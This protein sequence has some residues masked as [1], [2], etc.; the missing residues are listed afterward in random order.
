VRRTP[1]PAATAFVP[2]D[3]KGG[4]NNWSFA[5]NC[6]EVEARSRFVWANS[7][8]VCFGTFR[9]CDYARAKSLSTRGS[10]HI[11]TLS[12]GYWIALR[13]LVFDKLFSTYPVKLSVRSGIE[14]L[15]SNPVRPI[16]T[17][18]VENPTGQLAESPTG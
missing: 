13:V 9:R 17:V 15:E 1:A 11:M 10:V 12:R 2:R 18:H 3:E 8:N 6:E 7:V 5:H 16:G 14:D 4:N